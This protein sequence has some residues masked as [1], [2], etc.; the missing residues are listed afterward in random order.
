MATQQRASK[1]FLVLACLVILTCMT[2]RMAGMHLLAKSLQP[3]D[4][5]TNVMLG[6]NNSDSGSDSDSLTPCELSAK[7][8]L[9]ANGMA[10]EH[11]FFALLLFIVLLLEPSRQL[12][13]RLPPIR[14]VSLPRL[15]VH[16]R[17]CV[18]QE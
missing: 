15:R 18:F 9:A 1:W 13:L 6:A 3:V 8:L 12:R 17:L 2:Q 16:L 11:V 14:P 7:S 10:V 5:V 4:N